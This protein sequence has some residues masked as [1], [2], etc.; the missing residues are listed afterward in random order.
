M[1][2][3]VYRSMLS[4]QPSE[5]SNGRQRRLFYGLGLQREKHICASG[6]YQAFAPT[7]HH[8]PK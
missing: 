7:Q 2:V 3:V 5:D 6:S 1:D 4:K 8:Q